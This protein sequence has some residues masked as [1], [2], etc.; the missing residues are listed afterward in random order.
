MK[1]V[2]LGSP[3]II[4][5]LRGGAE[6]ARSAAGKC[7][8]SSD[9]AHPTG[10]GG[11][12]GGLGEGGAADHRGGAPILGGVH[13]LLEAERNVV[14]VVVSL[15]TSSGTVRHEPPSP[16]RPPPR[17]QRPTTSQPAAPD[18]STPSRPWPL[19][20][21]NSFSRGWFQPAPVLACACSDRG[22]AGPGGGGRK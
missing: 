21:A 5:H 4:S 22:S 16:R 14:G 9:I 13:V 15:Q 20:I 17:Q 10:G 12:E 7:D 6:T 19:A 11:G 3:S 1:K 18:R 8:L 2:A